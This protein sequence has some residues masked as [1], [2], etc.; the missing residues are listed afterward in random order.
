MGQT[1][2]EYGELHPATSN[3]VRNYEQDHLL[4]DKE[5]AWKRIMVQVYEQFK[6][7]FYPQLDLHSRSTQ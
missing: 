3:L 1:V 5:K 4:S 6:Y 7:S 2:Q